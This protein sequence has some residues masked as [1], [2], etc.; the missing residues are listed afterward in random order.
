MVEAPAPAVRPRA[1]PRRA[2]PVWRAGDRVIGLVSGRIRYKILTPLIVILLILSLLAIYVVTQLVTQSLD[3]QFMNK[4]LDRGRAAKETVLTIEREN[5]QSLRLMTNTLGVPEAID[6]RDPLALQNLLLPLQANAK[7]DLVDVIAADGTPVFMLR[8]D[9]VNNTLGPV[10]DPQIGASALAGKVLTGQTDA[11]GDKYSDLVTLSWGKA[12]YTAAS[13][14]LNG[15]IAGVIL[16]GSPLE[17]VIDLISR[18]A[19]VSITIYAPDGKIVVTTLPLA[20]AIAAATAIGDPPPVLDLDAALDTQAVS[21]SPTLASRPLTLA[22]RTYRDLTGAMIVRGVPVAPMGVTVRITTIQAASEAT[23]LQLTIVFSVVILVVLA[24]GFWVASLITRPLGILV[25]AND[26]VSQGD[27]TRTVAVTSRDETGRLTASFNHMVEGLRERE[28]VKNMFSQYVTKQ[29]SDA[30]LNGS[31]KLGGERMHV[32][33]LL[34]DVRSFTT[35]SESMEP[36]QLITMLNRYFEY[37][38]DSIIEFDGILDKFIG[39]GILVEYN[40]PLPQER[41]SLR[42]VLNALRMRELLAKFNAEQV[43]KGE[44]ILKIGIGVHCGPAVLGNIGAEGKKLEYTAMGDTVNVTARL[45]SATKEVG[46]DIVISAD[47]YAEVR[48]FVDVSAPL[49]LSLKGKT[50]P[51]MAHIL[52]GLKPGL[53]LGK[54]LI[55]MSPEEAQEVVLAAGG[56]LSEM[57]RLNGHAGGYHTNGTHVEAEPAMPVESEAGAATAATGAP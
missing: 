36:E 1:Q 6:A 2:S 57:P 14:Q 9:E 26:K 50:E 17:R 7:I 51:V 16:V 25:A 47:L 49:A 29:V 19:Q 54:H 42:S 18:E 13:V 48:D 31:V 4:L 43:A 41:Y 24:S 35:I 27:L 5:L 44:I 21:D 12:I 22:G 45:E 46:A 40:C 10:I 32:A 11:L 3:E 33:I 53:T 55:D 37:M 30:V 39:D 52:I 15:Q 28:K 34:S 23:R 38:I 8:S 20:D 56:S